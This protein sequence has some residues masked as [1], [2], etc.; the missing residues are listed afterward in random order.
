[1]KWRHYLIMCFGAKIKVALMHSKKAM[2]L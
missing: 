1:M 2:S